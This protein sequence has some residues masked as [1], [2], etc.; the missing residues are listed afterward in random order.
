MEAYDNVSS[1]HEL[2]IEITIN[3]PDQPS[4]SVQKTVQA[5]TD[6]VSLSLGECSCCLMGSH[7]VI[8]LQYSYKIIHAVSN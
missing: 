6:D 4:R 1:V 8:F 5:N 7:I 2:G 3:M